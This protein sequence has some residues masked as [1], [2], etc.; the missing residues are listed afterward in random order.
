[1]SQKGG[2]MKPSIYAV[3]NA[4]QPRSNLN[5]KSRVLNRIHSQLSTQR[6][7]PAAVPFP[8]EGPGGRGSLVSTLTTTDTHY[9]NLRPTIP[10]SVTLED[11]R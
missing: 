11:A 4:S 2:G 3:V 1:M 5:S 9:T 8:L 7:Y 6:T 10:T